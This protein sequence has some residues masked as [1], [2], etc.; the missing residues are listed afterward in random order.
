MAFALIDILIEGVRTNLFRN[1]LKVIAD[2]LWIFVKFPLAEIRWE[3]F[4]W[5]N[6]K[7]RFVFDFH[8][9]FHAFL[10]LNFQRISQRIAMECQMVSL[11]SIYLVLLSMVA[12]RL[13]TVNEFWR[14][15]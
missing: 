11:A 5:I 9:F 3:V 6:E 12:A 7:Q 2:L 4:F 10:D 8:L 15:V 14:E 1:W 13:P